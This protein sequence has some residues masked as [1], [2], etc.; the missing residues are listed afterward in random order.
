MPTGPKGQK[1]PADVV[2]NAVHVMKV[3]TGEIV[4]ERH[5]RPSVAPHETQATITGFEAESIRALQ[6]SREG[7]RLRR[8]GRAVCRDGGEAGEGRAAAQTRPQAQGC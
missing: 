4:E 5:Q 3:L 8:L 1:R 6:G 7:S 2:G